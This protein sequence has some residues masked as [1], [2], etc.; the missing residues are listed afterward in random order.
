MRL[1]LPKALLFFAASYCLGQQTAASSLPTDP[2]AILDAAQPLYDFSSADLKP[3]HLR[4]SYQLYD[5]KEN[6]TE[7]GTFEYWW[8][9]P[10]AHRSS[11]TRGNVSYSTWQLAG[12]GHAH[13]GSSEPLKYVESKLEQA[14][15]S[16]LP[17]ERTMNSDYT[18][19]EKRAYGKDSKALQCVM[20]GPK[21]KEV[22]TAPMG[23]FPTYCFNSS[24]PA[25]VAYFAYAAPIAEFNQIVKVQGRYLPKQI[26]ILSSGRKKLLTA[27]V[28]MVNGISPQDAA[29]TPPEDVKA[30]HPPQN[31][32]VVGVPG[33]T[34]SQDDVAKIVVALG[35]DS[36]PIAISSGVAMGLALSRPA[37]IYPEDAKTAGISGRVIIQAVI[38]KDG[39]IHDMQ[40]LSAPSASL[41][42]AS[43]GA[44]S[45][46]RYRPY[47]F[48]GEPVDVQTT[49]NVIFSLG[50]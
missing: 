20:V 16:P 18:Q 40:V 45:Q 41:A 14:F 33:S 28:E 7:Q 6:P 44:V 24:Q 36:N 5:E 34:P 31:V 50:N 17:S 19:L 26:T 38:G 47:L 32:K 3:W 29:L 42:A 22:S 4:A 49:I 23:L 37:P 21:M 35:S 2:H 48:N 30:S 46:W 12:H 13:M 15:F 9:S 10:Q 27:S 8:A 25:L 39:W 11:W 43:L 1:V